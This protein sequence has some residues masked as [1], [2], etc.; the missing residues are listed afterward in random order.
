[1]S[2]ALIILRQLST[3]HRWLI[4]YGGAL[5]AVA[6]GLLLRVGVT[7][8][9]GPD[10]P[11]YITFYPAVMAVALVA[12]LGPGLLATAAAA[13]AVDYWILPPHGWA[14][15][16]FVDAVGLALFSAMGLFMSV[17]A[18]LYRRNRDQVASYDREAALRESQGRLAAFA[19]ASFEGIVQSEAG[20]VLDCNEQFARISGYSVE[21]LR[22]VEIASLIAPEDRDRVLASI[23]QGRESITEHAMLR[24]DGTRIVVESHGRPIMAGRAG[25][26]TAVR[27]ITER[28]QAEEAMRQLNTELR[29]RIVDLQTSNEEVRASRHAALNLME[30]AISARQ[31]A[32]EASVQ[33]RSTA[34]QRRLALEAACLGAWDYDFEHGEVLWDERCRQIWGIP[35][36]AKIDYAKAMADIHPADRAAVDEAVQQALTGRSGGAYHREF[37]VVWP[38]GSVHWI[39]SHGRAYFRS[40]EDERRPVRFIGLNREVTEER[41]AAEAL[42]QSEE[43][44]RGLVELSPEA[45]LVN[46]NNRIV[47]VNPAALRLFGASSVEELLGKSPFELFHRDYHQV[48]RA[49]IHKLLGGERVP[50]LEQK[51]I[52]QDSAVVDVEVAASPVTDQGQRAILVLVRDITERKQA[53]AALL[54]AA[55]E[56]ERSNLDLEQ[57]AYVASHDLQEPLR[58]VGG[59]VKLLQH[60]FQGRLDSKGLECIAGAADGAAR[61]ERLIADL[62]AYSRVGTHGKT[63][64]L[65]DLNQVLDNAL[66]NLHEVL[67]TTQATVTREGLPQVMVDA[68]QFVQL[69]QNL[70]GNAL[71]FRGERRPE[72]QVGGRRQ[73]GQ[74]VLWVRDNGIGIEPQYFE[75]IFQIFQRLHTRQA[76]PGTGIGLA[77]CKKV[78][79]RHGGRIWVDSKPGEGATFSFT[80]AAD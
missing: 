67:E 47:L 77:I 64:V 48:M 7:A 33:L 10:L 24:K 5:V 25:R 57:F 13:L 20:R 9:V 62:L 44:Y 3:E 54:Q 58:A 51:I 6:G 73:D 52:R 53:Q 41:Q 15:G 21:E 75:R 42:R 80:V 79:E 28:K 23:D 59:Y 76:Y 78:V 34:E 36:A 70:I 39:A 61:M 68:A 50:V 55:A 12:G 65:A 14:I 11:T 26:H 37:R 45:V 30:D 56:L 18:E 60:R 72:I 17:V 49:R 40:E 71:K 22:G 16:R 46:R 31:Q 63:P 66:K 1:V 29:Q 8:W 32:E 27:D 69:F 19:E 43:R 38:D 4:R 74:W 35:Q 2:E